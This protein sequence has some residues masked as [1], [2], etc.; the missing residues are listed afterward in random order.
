[1]T[2]ISQKF[3][4]LS[5]IMRPIKYTF[6]ILTFLFIFFIGNEKL[7]AQNFPIQIN[8]NIAPPYSPYLSDYGYDNRLSLNVL[9]KEFNRQNLSIRLNLKIESPAL[10]I[11]IQTSQ[12]FSPIYQISGG[13]SLFLTGDDLAPYF[14]PYNLDFAGISREEILRTK[15]LPEGI[16]SISFRAVEL[17]SGRNTVISNELLSSVIAPIW[18]ILPPIIQYPL[19]NAIENKQNL[20]NLPII[21]QWLRPPNA[22]GNTEF[23]FRITELSDAKQAQKMNSTQG[24]FSLGQPIYEVITQSPTLAYGNNAEPPLTL[25]RQYAIQVKAQDPEGRSLF[26]NDGLSEVVVFQYG[27]GCPLI[28]NLEAA[29]Q[30]HRRAKI[31]WQA[32]P[33]QTNYTLFYRKEGTEQWYPEETYLNEIAL[34]DLDPNTTYEYKV[35]ASCNAANSGDSEIQQ[36]S[37]EAMPEIAFECG[38]ESNVLI[39][40]TNP[41]TNDLNI[42][43]IFYASDFQIFVTKAENKGGG[44]FSGIGWASIPAFQMLQIVVEFDNITLNT[45]N[46]LIEGE[47][48]SS[49]SEE[50][51]YGFAEKQVFEEPIEDLK[52]QDGKM[53]FRV[54][55][56]LKEVTLGEKFVLEDPNYIYKIDEEGNI[57]EESKEEVDYENMGVTELLEE[58]KKLRDE[59]RDAAERGQLSEADELLERA[60]QLTKRA[61]ELGGELVG[62]AKILWLSVQELIMEKQKDFDEKTIEWLTAKQK[63][64]EMARQV[65]SQ[66][67]SGVIPSTDPDASAFFTFERTNK[68]SKSEL[69]ERKNNI[70]NF[71]EYDDA[72]GIELEKLDTWLSIALIYLVIERYTEIENILELEKV[73][74]NNAKW[75]FEK[76]VEEEAKLDEEMNKQA[77]EDAL[78]EIMKEDLKKFVNEWILTELENILS[79]E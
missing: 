54:G 76:Y 11:T 75:L 48:Y 55:G 51:A 23:V 29:V 78:V 21:F 70:A 8:L 61:I 65:N 1:L 10:G 3:L 59:A 39:E 18:T 41:K 69:E 63:K 22:P 28:K 42:G 20:E 27:S 26:E 9:L 56:E 33:G 74:K 47:V 71:S 45:E 77:K 64:E 6:L 36:F 25:G 7:I 50:K 58:A 34:D 17:E 2:I 19:P 30:D 16:Y 57:T 38:A 68:L 62:F 37:T 67:N 32:Q 66:F 79:D 46:Q 15:R 5:S 60:E 4:L 40:N 31:T 12:N 44:K 43:D 13:E 24:L 52:K 49:Y 72:R 73:L 14:N 35:V 53:L